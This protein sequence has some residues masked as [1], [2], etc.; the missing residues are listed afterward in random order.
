MENDRNLFNTTYSIPAPA[1]TGPRWYS[2]A[3]K[4][5]VDIAAAALG[6]LLLSPVP[7]PPA[8]ASFA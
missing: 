1:P 6:L 7:S 2:S 3:A 4:R 8:C 5:L